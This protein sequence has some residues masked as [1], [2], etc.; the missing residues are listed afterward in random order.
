MAVRNWRC[1]LFAALLC[2]QNT[3]C[4][5][6]RMLAISVFPILSNYSVCRFLYCYKSRFVDSDVS[7]RLLVV[8]GIMFQDVT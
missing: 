4:N 5:L 8:A 6:F 1:C 2:Y 7:F 3:V